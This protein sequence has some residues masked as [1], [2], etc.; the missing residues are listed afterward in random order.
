MMKNIVHSPHIVDRECSKCISGSI[1]TYHSVRYSLSVTY[2]AIP[3]HDCKCSGC[4]YTQV[5]RPKSKACTVMSPSL[6]NFS[7]WFEAYGI[8]SYIS[9]IGPNVI[10]KHRGHWLKNRKLR[11]WLP[12][13]QNAHSSRSVW[14]RLPGLPSI[15]LS[16]ITRCIVAGYSPGPG[17][18]NFCL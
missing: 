3:S 2:V 8:L 5:T 1:I 10:M 13:W 16:F 18:H 14:W 9:V 4:V 6:G 7:P 11:Q 12:G 17:P 15:P